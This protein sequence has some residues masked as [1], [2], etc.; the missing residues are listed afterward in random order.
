MGPIR[1]DASRPW[2]NSAS[3][4]NSATATAAQILTAAARRD[5]HPAGADADV[6]AASEGE[7]EGI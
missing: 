5:N 2:L 7:A 6:E 4:I 1:N 3:T